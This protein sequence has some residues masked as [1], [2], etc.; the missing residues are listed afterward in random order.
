MKCHDSCISLLLFPFWYSQFHHTKMADSRSTTEEGSTNDDEHIYAN[1]QEME[2]ESRRQGQPPVP[3]SADEAIRDVGD[4]WYEYITDTG[5]FVLFS[6]KISKF[7]K[8]VVFGLAL[9]N[10]I[11][12]QIRTYPKKELTSRLEFKRK[13]MCFIFFMFHLFVGLTSAIMK[14]M[15]AAGNHH[16]F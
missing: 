15:I 11:T 12:Y 5:R 2:E 1:V 7:L 4:G 9:R 6:L 10:N 13:W 16:D 8:T 14:Q 3:G